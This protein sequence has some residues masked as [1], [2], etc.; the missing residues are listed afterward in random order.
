[1]IVIIIIIIIIIKTHFIYNP[2]INKAI[3][4]N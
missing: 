4:N 2:S 3:Y 1:M